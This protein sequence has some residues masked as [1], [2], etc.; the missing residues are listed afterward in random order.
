MTV[1]PVAGSADLI[2]R[3]VCQLLSMRVDSD[4]APWLRR[5]LRYFRLK[6]TETSFVSTCSI[7]EA[8]VSLEDLLLTSS[9]LSPAPNLVKSQGPSG[10]FH[11][12]IKRIRVS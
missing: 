6:A 2:C 4:V 7:L 10:P 11:S 1:A 3:T 9:Y 12:G 8:F 5:H